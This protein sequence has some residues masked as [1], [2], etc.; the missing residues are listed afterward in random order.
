MPLSHPLIC[1]ECHS[2][3]ALIIHTL[4]CNIEPVQLRRFAEYGLF[5]HIVTPPFRH[6]VSTEDDAV[7]GLAE[8]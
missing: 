2:Y 5:I 1:F 8:S 3:I 6:I 4:Y 7:A